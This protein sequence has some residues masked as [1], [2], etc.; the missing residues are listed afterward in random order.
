MSINSEKK[1]RKNSEKRQRS[2]PFIRAILKKIFYPW[3]PIVLYAPG[4]F[5]NPYQ[6]L[7]YSGFKAHVTPVKID[8]VLR[9]RKYHLSK[10]LHLHWDEGLL[11]KS[12]KIQSD[13]AK[14][15]IKI[16]QET[17]GK[18]IW[19]VHNMFP[20]ELV[21]NQEKELFLSNRAFM[22]KYADKIHVHNTYSRQYLIDNFDVDEN[23]IFVIAHPS[24]LE[25]YCVD[26]AHQKF[27]E[28]KS[29]LL[30]GNMRSY[31]GLDLVAQA[32]L[33]VINKNDVFDF[34]IA[35]HGADQVDL[36]G[37]SPLIPVRFSSGYISDKQVEE[38]YAAADFAIFGFKAILTSGSVLLAISFGVPPIAPAHPALIDSL[39][40]EL[41]DL[42]YKPN[43]AADFARVIDYAISLDE[44]T[45]SKK[46]VACNLFSEK[47]KPSIISSELE[48]L[49]F[50]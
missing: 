48:K 23:K 30:F 38:F 19:T 1:I 46:V 21:S 45:Y 10:I 8:K 12:D 24:Y 16:F 39:P 18:I 15:T 17:G 32:F 25:W 44:Q 6:S 41:H 7:L 43:D 13:F 31:K 47:T 20:H 36:N 34:H 35:G 49:I 37:L 11:P 14:K 9:Y 22:C 33:R 2:H 28:K 26:R 40:Q 27:S 4:N 3:K 42:L 50:N 5:Q 29:F